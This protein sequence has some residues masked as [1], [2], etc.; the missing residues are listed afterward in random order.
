[1]SDI[2]YSP[3]SKRRKGLPFRIQIEPRLT[4]PPRWYPFAVSLGAVIVA[5]TIGGIVIALAGGDPL[6][7]Y[8]H[9]ARASFGSLGVFSD[10]L[11]K[12]TPLIL[13][14][15]ACTVAFSMRLW[16]IGAEGQLYMGAFGAS[17]VVLISSPASRSLLIASTMSPLR[18]GT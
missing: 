16:N 9:I 14:G 3:P 7:S 10:T 12:A 5:L 1:M 2:T 11:V 13:V 8:A 6:R 17:A 4:E 18:G 15:L